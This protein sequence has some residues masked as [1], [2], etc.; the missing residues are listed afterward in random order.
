MQNTKSVDK[1]G[2]KQSQWIT[3]DQG[4]FTDR[5]ALGKSMVSG[6]FN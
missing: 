6:A 1:L 5:Y 4:K 2:N 3:S